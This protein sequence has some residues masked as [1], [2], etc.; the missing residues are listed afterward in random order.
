MSQVDADTEATELLEQ[1][2]ETEGDCSSEDGIDL[3]DES[4]AFDE[5]DDSSDDPDFIPSTPPRLRG[6][7]FFKLFSRKQRKNPTVRNPDSGTTLKNSR[8][9]I[10]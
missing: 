2:L 4:E 3:S 5:S 6:S 7:P 9:N 8:F 1:A 10:F